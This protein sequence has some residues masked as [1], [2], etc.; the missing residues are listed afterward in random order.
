MKVVKIMNEWI[1]LGKI[2]STHGIKG[3]IRILS[4]FERKKEVLV[5]SFLIYIDHQP[6]E[7]TSYRHHKNYEMIC[8]KEY[9]TIN[10]VLPFIKKDVYIHRDDL[11]KSDEDYV[12]QDLIG[13]N[14]I[15]NKKSIGQVQ[16]IV[17][18]KAYY[19]L[20]VKEKNHTFYI[21]NLP[22]YIKKVDI[23]KKEIYTE[24]AQG[25]ML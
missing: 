17:Y 18:N 23:Q 12:L 25:L 4:N 21:P 19:L 1:Y 9:E 13:C 10:D 3:E 22:E 20:Q 7:I 5:P 24:N 6:Y 14:V 8:L 16:E 11:K 2:V 15:E